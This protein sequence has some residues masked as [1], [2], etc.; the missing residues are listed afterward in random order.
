MD[1]FA[2]AGG[3]SWGLQQAGMQCLLASDYWEDALVTYRHNMP[4][5]PAVN[6]DIRD[7]TV[8]KLTKMLPAKPDWIVGG[9]P[10]QGY[11]T[12]GKRNRDDPRNVLFMEFRKL[13]A[14]IKPQGFLIE[15]VLGLKDMSFEQEVAESFKR[16]G[17]RV[18]FMILTSA[19]H[20]VPQLRRRVLFVGHRERGLF[21]GPAVTHDVEMYVT[22]ADAISDLPPLAA[23]ERTDRYRKQPSTPYQ[24]LMR[25]PGD[26]LQ[27][28]QV[29]KHPE[30]LVTA[31]SFI[32]DG[33]NRTAIPPEYQPRTGFH[34]SYSR[35]AS[36]L[37]AVAITQNLGKPSGT[38]CIHPTQHRGLTTREGARLQSFPDRFHFV[39]G[40][41]SQRLQVGNAVPPLLAQ[42]VG[43]ALSDSVRW[44]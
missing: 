40:V 37:P 36:W 20:G 42:A 23:G 35:L 13:V 14:G 17:Y 10:C 15:N 5:H 31:I 12:V 3:L 24:K 30:H 29:S 32:P 26:K 38:R 25:L 8:S 27:G 6:A 33:G 7:L 9:P 21:K 18:R 44:S 2:G 43:E 19:E 4:D 39:G 34:N 28:H 11:S 1:L 41:T 22:V 16:L